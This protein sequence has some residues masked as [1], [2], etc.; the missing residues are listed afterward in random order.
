[1][2]SREK[3]EKIEEAR[4]ILWE[5]QKDLR[6]ALEIL[7]PY[8]APL[9]KSWLRTSLY[10]IYFITSTMLSYPRVLE[11]FKEKGR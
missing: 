5:V 7:E 2:A 6:R 10:R 8:P 4:K 11:L 9:L 1:M 3:I